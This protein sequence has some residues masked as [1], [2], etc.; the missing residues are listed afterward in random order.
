MANE[1]HR[2]DGFAAGFEA[3]QAGADEDANPYEE[4][5][6]QWRDWNEGWESAFDETDAPSK[7]SGGE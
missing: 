3:C 7:P 4:G 2:K 6:G 1:H 5:S